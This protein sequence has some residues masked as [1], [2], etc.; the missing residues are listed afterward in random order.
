MATLEEL[1]RRKKQIEAQISDKKRA[2]A[3]EERKARNHALMVAGGLV[4]QHAPDGDWKRIDWDKL[5]EWLKRYG[6]K[7]T[8]CKTEFLPTDKAYKRLREWE[9][10]KQNAEESSS[11]NGNDR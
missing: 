9:H 7:I 5:A 2:L 1:Q 11:S 10:P 4:M 8:E 3:R 6:Y